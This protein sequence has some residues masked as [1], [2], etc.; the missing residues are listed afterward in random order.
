MSLFTF[1]QS[2]YM[3]TILKPENDLQVHIFFTYCTKTTKTEKDTK[4]HAPRI[5]IC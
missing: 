3:M 2:S 4:I 1:D 5:P